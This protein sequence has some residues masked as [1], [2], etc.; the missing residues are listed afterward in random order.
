MQPPEN[1]RSLNMQETVELEKAFCCRLI[2]IWSDES[3]FTSQWWSSFLSRYPSLKVEEILQRRYFPGL[4]RQSA[5]SWKVDSEFSSTCWNFCIRNYP[6]LCFSKYLCHPRCNNSTHQTGRFCVLSSQALGGN[7]AFANYPV[8]YCS[9]YLLRLISIQSVI[10][11]ILGKL[12]SD[13]LWST[14]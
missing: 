8:P 13:H 10:G 1:I 3:V 11:K 5:S 9:K 7:F 6:V 12:L 14:L 2:E 4:K